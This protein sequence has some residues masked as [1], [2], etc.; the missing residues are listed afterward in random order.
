MPNLKIFVD[1]ALFPACRAE[2]AGV[3]LPLRDLLCRELGVP[4]GACQ[5]SVLS[6]MSLPDMPRVNV[7]VHI[8]PKSDRTRER[9]LSLCG[10]LRELV[11]AAT[12]APVA[13]R[14]TTLDPACYIA[15][16]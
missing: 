14:L 11:G 16:K 1:E 5:F 10:K 15:L 7:E 3:L 9:L 6:V 2:L 13:V 12:G 4:V 8:L